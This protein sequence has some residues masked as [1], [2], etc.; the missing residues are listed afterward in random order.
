MPLTVRP[1]DAPAG[2][3]VI[4]L[5]VD[6]IDSSSFA[7]VS[8]AF[9]DFGFLVFRDQHLTPESHAAFSAKFGALNLR[10]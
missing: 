9:L 2:A 10:I 7:Q 8:K 5:K 1:F 3:E 6:Q 4:G